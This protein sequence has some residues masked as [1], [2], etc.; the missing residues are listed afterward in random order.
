MFVTTL[1]IRVR[2]GVGIG[3]WRLRVRTWVIECALSVVIPRKPLV[4]VLILNPVPFECFGRVSR[5]SAYDIAYLMLYNT[6][7]LGNI[8]MYTFGMIMLWKW[9]SFSFEKNKSG[10]HTRLASVSVRYFIL[11]GKNI[12]SYCFVCYIAVVSTHTFGNH[13]V[14]NVV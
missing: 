5:P 9:P 13:N 7:P 2:A 1:R 14:E 8:L 6:N 11:P 12:D 4:V 10:I 3:N